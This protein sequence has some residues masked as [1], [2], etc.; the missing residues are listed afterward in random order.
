MDGLASTT[1][2]DGHN[3]QYAAGGSGPLSLQLVKD[4][5]HIQIRGVVIDGIS[6]MSSAFPIPAAT[7]LGLPGAVELGPRWI[8]WHLSWIRSVVTWA[9]QFPSSDPEAIWRTLVIDRDTRYGQEGAKKRPLPVDELFTWVHNSETADHDVDHLPIYESQADALP[10]GGAGG[11]NLLINMTPALLGRRV[12]R[13]RAGTFAT[14]PVATESTDVVAVFQGVPI[15][16]VLRTSE[17]G[18]RVVGPSY[19]HGLMNGEA[20]T[21]GSRLTDIV[22]V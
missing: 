20:L 12:A 3:D 2:A 16:F 19:V 13:T 8:E 17:D 10:P 11:G 4:N 14:V 15:P 5:E 7:Y 21:R 18:Y 9:A 6:A 1:D 22:L